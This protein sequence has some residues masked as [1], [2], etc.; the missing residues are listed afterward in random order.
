MEATVQEPVVTTA[1]PLLAAVTF[2]VAGVATI[3]VAATP[4]LT[5]LFLSIRVAAIRGICCCCSAALIIVI[6]FFT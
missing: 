2:L 6:A 4:L 5:I 1:T 3:S